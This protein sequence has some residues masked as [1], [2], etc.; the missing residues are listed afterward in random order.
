MANILLGCPIADRQTGLYLYN[1]LI[2]MGHKVAIFDWKAILQEYGEDGLN[3]EFVKAVAQLKPDISIICKGLGFR[4]ESIEKAKEIHNAPIVNWIFDV[5][6][7]GTYVKDVKPYVDMISACNRFYTIDNDA[8]KE[9]TELGIDCKWLTE[10]CYL[11]DHGDQIY[12]INQ[13]KMFGADVVFVGSVGMI[14]PNREKFLKRIYDEG[15]NL[16]IYGDIYYP[17][18]EEPEFVK[19]CHT[20]YAAIN[21]KHSIICEA[22]KVVIGIDGWPHRE[23]SWSAR[24]YRTMCAGGF[25]LTS[26]TNNIENHFKLGEHLDTFKDEDEL[27]DKL[28]YWLSNDKKRKEVAKAGQKHVI[29]NFQFKHALKQILDDFKIE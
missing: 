8:V 26:H 28:I 15:F 3:N 16:K 21:D 1:S 29:D 11:P 7:G 6:L 23:N 19:N 9:L 25:Y 13:A 14:H 22:S 12:N 27:I 2:Q 5:T 18:G 4:K 24:I 17:E 20:G 10:G